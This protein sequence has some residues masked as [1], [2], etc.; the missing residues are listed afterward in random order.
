[1]SIVVWEGVPVR[2]L[3][4]RLVEG[5]RVRQYLLSNRLMDFRSCMES[6]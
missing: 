4:T 6:C 3:S 2:A 5:K 1:M